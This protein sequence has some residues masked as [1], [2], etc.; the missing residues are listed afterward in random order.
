ME[1]NWI[2]PRDKLPDEGQLVILNHEGHNFY[3]ATYK[4]HEDYQNGIFVLNEEDD[5]IPCKLRKCDYIPISNSNDI[6]NNQPE[7]SKRE[8]LDCN[9]CKEIVRLMKYEL[10][11]KTLALIDISKMRCSEHCGNTVREAR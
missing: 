10:S 5:F 8:D 11:P 7:R 2:D 6:F 3:I 9:N 1:L 4:K